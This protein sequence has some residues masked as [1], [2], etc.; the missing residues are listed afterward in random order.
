MKKLICLLMV[1]FLFGCS[2]TGNKDNVLRVGM[3]CNYAP[4]NWTQIEESDTAVKI[5]EVDYCDGYDVM[6]ARMIAEELGM[7]LEIVKTEWEALIPA[8]NNNQIDLV[9][10]GMTDTPTRRE[11]VNF[12]S[13]Y[14]ESDMVVIVKKDS[15]L[16]NI[17]DIQELSGYKVLGQKNTT[18]DEIIDQIDG[19]IHVTPLSTYP[20]MILSLQ[21]NEVDA[22]TAELP[23]ATGVVAAN[24]DLT[25]VSFEEGKGFDVDTSVSI[26]VKKENTGLLNKVE[27]ALS[28]IDTDTR[29]NL[30][31]EAT[32][33]QPAL[34]E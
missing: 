6:I 24:P 16:V 12:T 18:Y 30:M 27:A 7:E 17:S 22:I 26:A 4:F 28:K 21:S 23:V 3:E 9:I 29:L 33:R 2:N 13:P 10:A 19:V 11:A 32:L 5:S 1:L 15:E 31:L 25:I 14:Y 8:L 20:R 34:E